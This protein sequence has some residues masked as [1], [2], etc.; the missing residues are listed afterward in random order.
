MYIQYVNHISTCPNFGIF[1]AYLKIAY[2]GKHKKQKFCSLLVV[3]HNFGLKNWKAYLY[4]VLK[5]ST[6]Y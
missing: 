6:D 5:V 1:I 2:N 4:L 3:T